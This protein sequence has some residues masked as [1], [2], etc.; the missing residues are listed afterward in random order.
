M[1]WE[2]KIDHHIV[3]QIISRW[4]WPCDFFCTENGCNLCGVLWGPLPIFYYDKNL[5]DL[6]YLSRAWVLKTRYSKSFY[7]QSFT[8]E[9]S[10]SPEEDQILTFYMCK[11]FTIHLKGYSEIQAEKS[12]FWNYKIST[13]DWDIARQAISCSFIFLWFTA[14]LGVTM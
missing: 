13:F 6:D 10:L 8:C 1:R 14:G 3:T 12:A 9:Q 4:C 2:L 7:E 5:V 11:V